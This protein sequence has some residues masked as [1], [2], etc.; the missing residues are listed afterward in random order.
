MTHLGAL[1]R[2]IALLFLTELLHYSQK[3]AF[4]IYR[5]NPAIPTG[6]RQVVK[7]HPVFGD[8]YRKRPSLI[9]TDYFTLKFVCSFVDLWFLRRHYLIWP[10]GQLYGPI[11]FAFLLFI[12]SFQTY[13]SFKSIILS[14]Y[15]RNASYLVTVC[16]TLVSVVHGA[17]IAWLCD[18][19]RLF[20]STR[21]S[22]CCLWSSVPYR[23]RLSK[24]TRLLFRC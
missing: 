11:W 20:A 13:F 18:R 6:K 16:S 9:L 12:F 2:T 22:P 1:V 14:I 7:G 19:R 4:D 8:V 23:A 21:V 10:L 17:G 15:F 3:W 24:G 5:L